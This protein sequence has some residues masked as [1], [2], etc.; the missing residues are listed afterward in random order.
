MSYLKAKSVSVDKEA[1]VCKV[2]C[3]SNNL[4][5][6]LFGWTNYFDIKDLLSEV[7]G[8]SIQF[9]RGEQNDKID[10]LVNF[11]DNIFKAKFNVGA[12]EVLYKMKDV[13]ESKVRCFDDLANGDL[14]PYFY[15]EANFWLDILNDKENIVFV[16]K[17]E[18]E[19]VE[20]FLKLIKRGRKRTD[21]ATR[22]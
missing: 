10:K 1:K 21:E 2:Y 11:Y 17:I 3:A 13:E 4:T 15:K 20:E 14:N 6:L 18:E 9:Y 5:P 8:G 7:A 19:F 12:W 16:R 22:N